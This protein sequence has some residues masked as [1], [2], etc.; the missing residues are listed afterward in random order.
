MQII[1]GNKDV[2]AVD[3]VHF[4]RG[5]EFACAH[6]RDSKDF[7]NVSKFEHSILKRTNAVDLLHWDL[8]N[9]MGNHVVIHIGKD[10][11]QKPSKGWE[12]YWWLII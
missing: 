6:N 10:K 1:I 8:L 7:I 9:T 3:W 2:E 4:T 12:S 5:D 11:D